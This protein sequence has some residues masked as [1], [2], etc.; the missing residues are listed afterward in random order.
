MEEVFEGI[1][2]DNKRFFTNNLIKGRKVYGEKLITFNNL[3]LRE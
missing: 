1:Y 2:K 3:E